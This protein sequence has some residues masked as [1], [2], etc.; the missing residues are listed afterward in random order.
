MIMIIPGRMEEL[1]NKCFERLSEEKLR[2]VL[3]AYEVYAIISGK[4]KTERILLLSNNWMCSGD[5][6]LEDVYGE[7]LVVRLEIVNQIIRYEKES[8]DL[9]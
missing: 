3:C 8:V 9:G 6:A 4:E 5:M 1:K 7:D 2:D